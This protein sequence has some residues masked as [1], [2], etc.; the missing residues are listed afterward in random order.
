MRQTRA[1]VLFILRSLV[2]ALLYRSH[3]TRTSIVCMHGIEEFPIFLAPPLPAVCFVHPW[4][5]FARSCPVTVYRLPI[6]LPAKSAFFALTGRCATVSVAHDAHIYCL[7]ARD[8]GVSY[9]GTPATCSL[10][11]SPLGFVRPFVPCDGL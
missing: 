7:Y 11:R 10:F 9:L 4:S 2:V 6:R 3:M 8:R 5:S 1:L